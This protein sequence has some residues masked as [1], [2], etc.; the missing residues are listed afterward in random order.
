[1]SEGLYQ[2]FAS[3]FPHDRSRP[4][5]ETPEGESQSYGEL[6]A[7]A[8]RVASLLGRCGVGVGDRVAENAIWSYEEPYDEVA[9]LRGCMAFYVDRVDALRE[10]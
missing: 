9:D 7:R 8:A 10:G 6:E 3:R 1:M 5:L 4:F 2:L